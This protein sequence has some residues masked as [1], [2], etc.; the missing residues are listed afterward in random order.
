MQYEVINL[1]TLDKPQNINLGVQCSDEEKVAFTGLF[2]EYKD[3]F[4][5]SYEYLKTFDTK[6]MQHVIPIK[7]LS[8]CNKDCGKCI[9][10]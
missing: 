10:A 7:E 4:A 2:K 9:L 8:L 5:W 6:I 1:G 3:E